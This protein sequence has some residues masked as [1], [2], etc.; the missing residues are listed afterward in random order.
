[1]TTDSKNP[2]ICP[3]PG[4]RPFTEE[5]SIF[6]KGRDFHIEQ[7]IAQLEVKKFIMLTGASGDGKSSVVYAGV[8]PNVRAGFFKAKFNKWVFVDFKPGRSPLKNMASS[9]ASHLGM[10]TGKVESR[11][12]SGF[13]SLLEVYKSSHYYLDTEDESYLKLD[14]NARKESK[15]KAANL[16]ILVDQFEE[17]FTNMENFSQGKPSLDAQLVVN[18]LLETAKI[19]SER[20]LPVYIIFTMRSD[21]IGQCAAF[22]GLPEYI[23]FSQFF[24]PRLKRKEI[25]EVIEEPVKMSDNRISR[26]LLETLVDELHEGFDQLPVLQHALNQIWQKAD[27]GESEMDL[28]HLAKLSGL[29]VSYLPENDQSDFREWY[30]TVL[31]NNQDIKEVIE[32]DFGKPSLE[33]VLNTHANELYNCAARYYEKNHPGAEPVSAADA[34]HIIKTAFQ[35]LTKIDASRAVRIRMTLQEVTDI[36]NLPHITPGIVGGILNIFR[37]QGNTFISPFILSEKPETN[38]LKTDTVLDITHESLIRNWELLRK[39]AKEENENWQNFLDFDKQLQRWINSDKSGGYLLPIGPLT[40]FENWF[41]RCKPNKYWL[42]KYDD[43]DIP[44]QEKLQYAEET[45]NNARQFLKRSARRL[46]ISRTVLKYGAQRI[47]S[48]LGLIFLFSAITYYTID[49]RKKQ[50]NAV[51]ERII[52]RGKELLASNK[53]KNNAKANFVIAYDRLHQGSFNSL[54]GNLNDTLAYDIAFQTLLNADNLSDPGRR[55]INPMLNP[56]ISFMDSSLFQLIKKDNSAR[57]LLKED[58]IKRI[59]EFLRLI[60]SVKISEKSFNSLPYFERYLPILSETIDRKLKWKN[61]SVTNIINFN[62][63]IELLINFSNDQSF[64]SSIKKRISPFENSTAN[65]LFNKIYPSSKKWNADYNDFLLHNGGYQMLAYFYVSEGNIHL[66]KNCVDSLLKYNENYQNYSNENFYDIIRLM[67][68]FGKFPNEDCEILLKNFEK[69]KKISRL[70]VLE[71]FMNKFTYDYSYSAKLRSNAYFNFIVLSNNNVEQQNKLWEYYL[72]HLKREN[73]NIDDLNFKLAIYYKKRGYNYFNTA[74]D[75]H[76]ADSCFNIAFSY[77]SL[78]PEK[79]VKGDFVVGYEGTERSKQIKRS[80]LF[81]YPAIIDDEEYYEPLDFMGE[82]EMV[83]FDYIIKNNCIKYFKTKEDYEALKKFSFFYYYDFKTTSSYRMNIDYSFFDFLKLISKAN[84]MAK[85]ILDTNFLNLVDVVRSFDK[86]NSSKG[87]GIYKEKILPYFN[88]IFTSDIQKE[89]YPIGQVYSYLMESLAV[90]LAT[91]ENDSLNK[92]ALTNQGENSSI[93]LEFGSCTKQAQTILNKLKAQYV[94]R[95]SLIKIS[96]KL[97]QKGPIENTFVYL[98][99][100]FKFI[101]TKPKFG[102][103]LFEVL[104]KIGSQS[105]YELAGNMIRDIDD[106]VK[107][108]ALKSFIR[109]VAYTGFY[110]KA[111]YYIPGYIASTNELELYNTILKTEIIRILKDKE[112]IDYELGWEESDYSFYNRNNWMENDFEDSD[113]SGGYIIFS[114]SE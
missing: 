63:S 60:V 53:V 111:W 65:N 61:D 8:I 81:L 56:L 109:G 113:D 110:Y 33:N 90:E 45:V 70:K 104:G 73:K 22:R 82:R 18:I 88:S 4:L 32:R 86:N 112:K 26:R 98:D 106:K 80:V 93:H 28:I 103:M 62:Q 50:N 47:A 75:R 9:L 34:R 67:I 99:S 7:I 71:N 49:F 31:E 17:F 91:C 15:R 40:F 77:Y 72:E 102:F 85:E 30:D 44:V 100:L 79:Y 11:L 94:K 78:L 42:A 76:K 97:Q 68:K 114:S 69:V 41:N 105:I 38:E 64:I 87:L 55:I 54:L 59:N 66:I 84:P 2:K 23:G 19:A 96:N 52:D 13:S 48:V 74:K 5:E 14:E 29:Q 10:E 1:M 107:F 51:I 58:N 46:F 21:F 24:V 43:S 36:I 3:Y 101:D 6:F 95:N 27:K 89:A 37:E 16:F 39:W 83:F 25:Y 92:A 20:N 35:C 12:K 108:F 57:G